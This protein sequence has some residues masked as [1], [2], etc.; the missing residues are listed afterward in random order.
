MK[1]YIGVDGGGTK[2]LYALFDENKNIL[3]TVKTGGTNHENMEGSFREASDI[4]I[5]GVNALLN[6]NNLAIDDI[7][8]SLMGLAGI[9]HKFQHDEMKRL[10]TEKGLKNFEIYNDGFIVIKAGSKNGCG[11]GLNLGTGT[12]CNSI[13]ENGSLLQLAGFGVLSGDTGNG[14]WIAERTFSSVYRDIVLMTRKTLMTEIF[15]KKTNISP[16]PKEFLPEVTKFDETDREEYCVILTD[17]FFEALNEGDK[18]AYSICLD[19]VD[20]CSD[21]ISAH[22]KRQVFNGDA[23]EVILSGSMN[24][25]MKNEIFIDLLK[26]ECYKKS[27]KNLSFVKLAAAPVTGCVNWIL[28]NEK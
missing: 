24:T 9:D 26:K 4:I 28:E 1:R 22:L 6:K 7:D 18:E 13:D 2:T 14:Y 5:E 20:N 17:T 15:C 23:T 10:L 3:D 25:K 11:I 12:C 19:M 16:T 21:L 27:G 8:G